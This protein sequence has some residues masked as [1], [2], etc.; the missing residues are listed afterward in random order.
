MTSIGT[1]PAVVAVNQDTGISQKRSAVDFW[2][3]YHEGSSAT[4]E[5]KEWIARNT[6]HL[7]DLLIS[8]LAEREEGRCRHHW[9]RTRTI[10]IME[11]GCGTSTLSRCLL[12]HLRQRR[13]QQLTSS[14]SSSYQVVA[15]DVSHVCIQNN[16]DRDFDFTTSLAGTDD[17]L[18]YEVLDAL[19]TADIDAKFQSE[20]SR[21]H[22][23]LDKG[24]LDTFLFR[25]TRGKKSTERH[26]PLLATLL[27]NVSKMLQPGGR[28]IV[29]SPRRRI[30]SLSQFI[31]FS[32]VTR[33][34]IEAASVGE[35][36]GNQGDNPSAR[37]YAFVCQRAEN[38]SNDA[39]GL[40]ETMSLFR[41]SLGLE[42]IT[43][44]SMC[45]GCLLTFAQFRNGESLSGRGKIRWLRKWKGH[46]QHC[47]KKT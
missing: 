44:D 9:H 6:P 18:R 45:Q 3:E 46:Q 35:L 21:Y 41:D 47:N 27:L 38:I 39:L 16:R 26:P 28:Y 43:D 15:T 8:G 23:V 30:P 11:I 2:N 13:E 20:E 37:A 1:T 25:N 29:V 40:G 7:L 10:R 22:V 12:S 17:N 4:D 42:N 24:C 33:L 36:D 5:P 34:D 31:G 19:S 32:E 14:S